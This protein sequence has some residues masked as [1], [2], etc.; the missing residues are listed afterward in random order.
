MPG[1]NPDRNSRFWRIFSYGFA[2]AIG[3]SALALLL[4]VVI[5]VAVRGC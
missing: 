4:I 3:A 2:G 1:K 5:F